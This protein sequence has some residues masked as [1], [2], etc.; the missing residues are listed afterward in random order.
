MLTKNFI[1]SQNFFEVAHDI[2]DITNLPVHPNQ[3]TREHILYGL[4]M[5]QQVFTFGKK[6][7]NL[8]QLLPSRRGDFGLR[9]ELTFALRLQTSSMYSII[10]ISVILVASY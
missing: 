1:P 8:G 2:F 7:R 3:H 6:R 10:F 5:I 4:T 9:T